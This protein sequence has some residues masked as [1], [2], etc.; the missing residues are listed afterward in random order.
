MVARWGVSPLGT[1]GP[2]MDAAFG[3]DD[4]LQH[5]IAGT[6]GNG[7]WGYIISTSDKDAGQRL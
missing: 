1:L 3:S 6:L 2:T 5:D 4:R 7:S